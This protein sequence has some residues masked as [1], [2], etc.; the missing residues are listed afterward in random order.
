MMRRAHKPSGRHAWRSLLWLL[1]GLLPGVCSLAMAAIAPDGREQ[2]KSKVILLHTDRLNYDEFRHPGAQILTG[3]VHFL[4][5]GVHMYCDSACF[6]E[7]TNSFNAYG[8][9]KMVQGDTLDLVGDMLL[10]DGLDQLARVRH[11]VVLTHLD[12]KLYTDSLDYDRLYELGYFFEGGRLV[13]KDN[14][15][16]SDWGQ[17]SPPTRQAVFNYNV[18]LEHP[19]FTLISDTLNYNTG[20]DV[21]EI[22]GPSNIDSG[23]NHIYSESGFYNTQSEQAIL[24]NRSIVTNNGRKMVA[25]SMFYDSQAGIGKGYNNVEYTDQVNKNMLT[26][27]YCYYEELTGYAEATDSAV[28]VDFSQADTMYMHADT[29]KLYTYHMDTDSMYREMRAYHKVR[30]YRTDV[31]SVCDSLVYNTKDSCMV[32]YKDPI[33]WNG[34]QQLLGEVIKIYMNDSTIERV[35]VIDQTLS[36]EQ[37]DTVH[38]NQV[39]GKEMTSY[40]RD[41]EMYQTWVNGNVYVDYYMFDDDSLMIGLNYT[42]TSELKLYMKDRKMHKIWMP[43]STGVIYPIVMIPQNRLY[44]SNFAW[45]DYIRPVSKED[46]FVWRPKRAGTELKTSVKHKPPLQTLDKL[47]SKAQPKTEKNE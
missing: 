2:S 5:D 6:Y 26:G 16:T 27:N 14:V 25:D 23:D 29:L 42:E 37:I 24:L 4:H 41:G 9:V 15:L 28:V 13:D 46:I 38:Y 34:T 17:Y 18:R 12:S 20:T 40:F 30:S 35:H 39:A 44:L 22:V 11:N 36:V 19:K 8:H 45:F 10:Y 43:A 3:N 33:V 47:R 7:A 21:A 32:M 31:Q 1:M